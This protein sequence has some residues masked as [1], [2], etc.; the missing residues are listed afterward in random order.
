MDNGYELWKTDGTAAG[1]VTVRDIN[2][3]TGN[4]VSTYMTA[5]MIA[6][7]T[8][9]YFDGSDGVH[10]LELWRS[11]GTEAGTTMVADIGTVS[12]GFESD[13]PGHDQRD[14]LLRRFRRVEHRGQIVAQ[15]RD[16]SRNHDRQGH[17]PHRQQH[18][19]AAHRRRQH[20]LL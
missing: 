4:G 13:L 11:D 8:F 17:Q 5:K 2:P 16:R 12:Y 18:D 14:Q 9:V 15:R 3:G 7:G 1:T 20:V 6:V 10:G 19:L